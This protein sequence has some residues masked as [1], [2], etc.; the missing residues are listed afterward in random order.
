MCIF[1]EERL[2]P[3]SL[4]QDGHDKPTACRSEDG[5]GQLAVQLCGQG[6]SVTSQQQRP[7]AQKSTVGRTS[8]AMPSTLLWEP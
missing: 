6:T 7:A 5:H 4:G 3:V 2:R 1:V 8:K